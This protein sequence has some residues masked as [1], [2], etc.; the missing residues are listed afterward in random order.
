LALLAA[1]LG[2]GLAYVLYGSRVL[3][4]DDI[5]RQLAGLYDFLVDKWRFD[6]LYDVMFV[7][8]VKI[9]ATWCQSFDKHVLDAVLDGSANWTVNVSKWDRWFDE[10]MVDGLVNLV[11]SA[12]HSVGAS[13]RVVQTGRLRQYVMWIAVGVVVLFAALFSALPK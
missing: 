2:L 7:C 10:G 5:R 4:P 9:V 11:A 1:V 12:T 6:T 13:L 3:N 8:P